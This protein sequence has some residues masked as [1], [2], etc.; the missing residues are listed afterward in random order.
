M[1][2]IAG[3]LLSVGLMSAAFA[4]YLKLML[5]LFITLTADGVTCGINGTS[6]VVILDIYM[7]YI[8]CMPYSI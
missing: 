8:L 7:L 4:L 2:T 5:S 6:K 1:V 3:W